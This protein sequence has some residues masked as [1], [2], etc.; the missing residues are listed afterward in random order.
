MLRTSKKHNRKKILAILALAFF[1]LNNAGVSLAQS[2][3]NNENP[4]SKENYSDAKKLQRVVYNII[5]PYLKG[6]N[7]LVDVKIKKQSFEVDSAGVQIT[8]VDTGM[9][10]DYLPGVADGSNVVINDNGV[11]APFNIGN[12]KTKT[13]VIVMDTCY[14]SNALAF[15][16]NLVRSTIPF[17]AANGDRLLVQSQVFPASP[18]SFP[19]VQKPVPNVA[20][21]SPFPIQQQ[22]SIQQT[23]PQVTK[24]ETPPESGSLNMAALIPYLIII[25]LFMLF[26]FVILYLLL[27]PKKKKQNEELQ[28]IHQKIEQLENAARAPIL[29]QHD[30]NLD[31]Y[32]K[33]ADMRS[34]VT[35]E[36][37]SN[38][39]KVAD[40]FNEWVEV[41]ESAGLQ[42]IVNIL[43]AT[44]PKLL[45]FLNSHLSKDNYHYVEISLDDN[46]PLV[47]EEQLKH[48]E[49]FKKEISTFN[50]APKTKERDIFH[51]LNQLN[52]QQI[53]YLIKEESEELAAIVLAQL[54]PK[55]CMSIIKNFDS[56]KQSIIL[57]KMSSIN[58]LSVAVYKEIASYFS[59]KAMSMNDMKY[60]SLDGLKTII[61][62]LD[63]LPTTEQK[64]YID[65]LAGYD[66]D[67]ARKIKERFITFEEIQDQ[68][69]YFL[70]R[71][72]EDV[73]S[74][75]IAKALINA[76]ET[77]VNKLI[78]LRPKRE[79]LLIKSEIDYN[80][81]L[82]IEEIEKARKVIL[83][84]LKLNLVA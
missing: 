63:T 12:G 1:M 56:T 38:K 67:L 5:Q 4:Y 40:L 23:F 84:K 73:D 82:L 33:L 28:S 15:I 81:D 51:F 47:P 77:T 48:I 21:L 72:L 8:D 19:P 16:D 50:T 17:D 10:V 22:P 35:K 54:N 39:N 80:K 36:F 37:I 2:N 7:F 25:L 55:R 13:V 26:A 52:E 3:N 76:N 46:P 34:Y 14:D 49:Q 79:Q 24:N 65:D 41:D 11:Y 74:G 60:V 29:I 27:R 64:K 75:T 57:Q 31:N 66:L 58:D 70:Q 30:D 62:L 9:A 45:P 43:K 6:T 71:A 42:K 83:D 44:N 32:A 78:S 53:M 61:S 68:D 59:A 18:N 20:S 69:D